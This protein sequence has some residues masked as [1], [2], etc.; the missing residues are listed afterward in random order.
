MRQTDMSV[1]MHLDIVSAEREIL[2]GVVEMVVASGDLG[3]IGIVPGHA[4][5]LTLLKPGDIRV[6][7][8][9]GQQE[10]YYV[11]GGMLE[12]QPYYVSILADTAERADNLDEAA[13]LAAKARAEEAIANKGAEL[14]YSIATAELARAA[15]QIRA[16]QKARK[17]LK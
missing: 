11:S 15:A 12:I 3:E 5:L 14:D 7:L 8:A 9:G 6:T 1:T 13:A 2:S 4:P 10:I 16:I 17:M